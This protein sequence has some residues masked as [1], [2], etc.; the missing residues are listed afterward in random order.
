MWLVY[1]V[2]IS[3]ASS[4]RIFSDCRPR[5][6]ANDNEVDI[7]T[8]TSYKINRI[9]SNQYFSQVGTDPIGQHQQAALKEQAE[10]SSRALERGLLHP[11]KNLN[12]PL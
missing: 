12:N 5:S 3:N 8:S 9:E 1:V 6:I 4:G 10:N 7:L 2:C 11:Q